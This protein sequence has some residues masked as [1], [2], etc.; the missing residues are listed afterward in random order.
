MSVDSV[1]PSRQIDQLTFTRFVAALSVVY[2]HYGSGIFPFNYATLDRLFLVGPISVSFFYALSGF[3]MAVVY[4]QKGGGPFDRKQYWQARFARIYPV[5]LLGLGATVLL[6]D[7]QRDASRKQLFSALLVQSWIP[8]YPMAYNYPGWSVSVEAFFYLLF[9]FLITAFA[10]ASLRK[11]SLTALFFWV[12]SSM[13]HVSLSTFLPVKPSSVLFDLLYYLPCLH[14]N[15]FLCGMLSGLLFLSH[16]RWLSERR[17][18]NV[19]LLIG[20]LAL[21]V[22]VLLGRQSLEHLPLKLALT[23]GAMAPLFLIFIYSLS[24]DRTIISRVLSA[25]LCL[26]LGD[27]SYSIYILH[28]P[29]FLAFQKVTASYHGTLSKVAVLHI[30]V[31]AVILLSVLSYLFIERPAR[32]GLKRLFQH[33]LRCREKIGETAPSVG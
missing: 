6:L 10:K 20:T 25:R 30:Y 11:L 3:I 28:V 5:Y 33:E 31:M 24:C 12:S 29:I 18:L 17:K 16:G 7:P 1:Q 14:L 21:I 26:L 23:N 15:T 9:P 4:T 32:S 19:A 22:A 2:Y 8:G 27:A 13:V